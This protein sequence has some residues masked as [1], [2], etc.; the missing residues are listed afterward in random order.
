MNLWQKII[1]LALTFILVFF[2]SLHIIV[3][4]KGKDILTQKL[5]EAFQ[6]KVRIVSL[7]TSFPANVLVKDVE[8]E[9]LFKIKEIFAGGGV[10]DIFSN[11]LSLSLLK[12]NQPV[13]SIERNLAQSAT[14][15]FVSS[16]Q[17]PQPNDNTAQ[18]II[19][20]PDKAQASI[21]P[22]VGA[23]NKF[24]PIKFL[25]NRLIVSDGALNFTDKLTDT[26]DILIKI[27]HLNLKINNLIPKIFASQTTTFDL[28][29]EIPWREGQE[30]GKIVTEGWINLVKKDIDATLKIE[31]IDGVYLYPYYSTWVDLEKA[32]IESAKLNFSSKI[33]GQNNNVTAE[34]H[35]ELADIVRRPLPLEQSDEKAAKITDA[36]LD[37]FK[38]MD[39]GKIVL[40]FIIRTKIDRPEFGFTQIKMAFE[41]KL[42][43]TKKTGP[44]DLLML[45][46][47]VLHLTIKGA[48]DF[49]KAIVDGTFNLAKE[50]RKVVEGT[51]K[52]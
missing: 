21:K 25:I 26:K 1:F 43:Q 15:A 51:S 40:D 7:S 28:N 49:S 17:Q 32:R 8:A 14:Q 34:C 44:Q 48:A 50:L 27:E 35:L 47:N 11:S 6:R 10:F 2:I 38:A 46:G 31:D 4:I 16:G 20:Q 18:K 41:N 22:V 39:Q 13:I 5:E 33:K 19:N 24:P 52:K 45:P 3:N 29:A 9:G 37:M 23:Q 12:I 30:R 42:A 36:V